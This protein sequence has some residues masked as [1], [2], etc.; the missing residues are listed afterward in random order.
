MEETSRQQKIERILQRFC[1]VKFLHYD[2]ID[3][4]L[5]QLQTITTTKGD[6]EKSLLFIVRLARK[7]LKKYNK[8]GTDAEK[9][10]RLRNVLSNAIDDL[11]NHLRIYFA[12]GFLESSN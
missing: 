6:E 5:S 11:T 1:Q 3:D 4:L 12:E 8:D 9:T 10:A 7:E 2:V